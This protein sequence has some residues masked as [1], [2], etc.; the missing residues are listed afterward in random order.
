MCIARIKGRVKQGGHYI[1]DIDVRRRYFRSLKN[2]WN[3][4]KD[5]VDSWGLYYNGSGQNIFVASGT[6]VDIDIL[7]PLLYNLFHKG[8]NQ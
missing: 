7:N 8:L 3:C 5:I 4:Y 6:K 1:P 2:F